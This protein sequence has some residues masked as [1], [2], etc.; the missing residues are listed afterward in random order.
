MQDTRKQ[1]DALPADW[2]ETPPSGL[3]EAEAHRKMQKQ[4]MQHGIK[5]ADCA[6]ILLGE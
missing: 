5:M 1:P 4:S 3:T 2:V 6:R